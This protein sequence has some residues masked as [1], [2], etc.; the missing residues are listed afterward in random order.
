VLHGSIEGIVEPPKLENLISDIRFKA[1]DN[2][3]PARHY[4]LFPHELPKAVHKLKYHFKNC[5]YALQSWHLLTSGKFIKTKAEM[6]ELLNDPAD[7]EVVRVARDW[8]KITDDLTARA[9]YY[10]E[11]LE[12]W[13]R[14]MI[15]K[16]K[17]YEET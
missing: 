2:L 6:L 1:S 16:L 15:I 4:L 7:K 12:R 11:L 17:S 9:R 14:G 10:I 13:S 5:F 3:H 8:Y